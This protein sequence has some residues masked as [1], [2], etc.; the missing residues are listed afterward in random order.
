MKTQQSLPALDAA[1]ENLQIVRAHLRQQWILADESSRPLIEADE[2]R[3]SVALQLIT[4]K[5]QAERTR[6]E[7]RMRGVK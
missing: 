4:Q 5:L 1:I 6:D 3:V 2:H 7:R